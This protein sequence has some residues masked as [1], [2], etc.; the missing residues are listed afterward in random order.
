MAGA[1]SG[2]RFVEIA[3]AGHLS[4][5]ESFTA[6]NEA[7]VGFLRDVSSQRRK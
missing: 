4:N 2:A 5:L 1:I 6:F 3:R 7:I